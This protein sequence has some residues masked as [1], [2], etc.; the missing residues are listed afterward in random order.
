MKN[1]I[2]NKLVKDLVN[3]KS[4]VVYITSQERKNELIEYVIDENDVYSLFIESREI[5]SVVFSELSE[6]TKFEYYLPKCSLK[7]FIIDNISVLS[8]DI[9]FV[10]NYYKYNYIVEHLSKIAKENHVNIILFDNNIKSPFYEYCD[11]CFSM[12]DNNIGRIKNRYGSD[13]VNGSNYIEY[14]TK[15]LSNLNYIVFK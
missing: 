9:V 5:G 12:I 15:N 10:D 1:E 14:I 3:N 13:F 6:M 2:K 7:T 11:F 8:T 4:D